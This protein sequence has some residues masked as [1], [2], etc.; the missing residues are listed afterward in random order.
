VMVEGEGMSIEDWAKAWTDPQTSGG[1]LLTMPEEDAVR[2]TEEYNEDY[3]RIIGEVK[4][5]GDW[6]VELK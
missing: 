4:K 5:R 6:A 2:F 1:L 3:V